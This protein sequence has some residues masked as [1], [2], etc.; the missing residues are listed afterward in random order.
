MK[1]S[2]GTFPIVSASSADGRTLVT[3]PRPESTSSDHWQALGRAVNA[4]GTLGPIHTLD[5]TP[6]G[7]TSESRLFRKFDVRQHAGRW[8]LLATRDTSYFTITPVSHDGNQ[9]A[10]PTRLNLHLELVG[11]GSETGIIRLSARGSSPDTL[12]LLD[13]SDLAIKPSFGLSSLPF[14]ESMAWSGEELLLLRRHPGSSHV[15]DFFT[16][17]PVDVALGDL[18]GQIFRDDYAARNGIG[19]KVA[20][21]DT[22]V[23]TR[24]RDMTEVRSSDTPLTYRLRVA[25]RSLSRC[26]LGRNAAFAARARRPT[27]PS[28]AGCLVCF[29]RGTSAPT[30]SFPQTWRCPAPLSAYTHPTTGDTKR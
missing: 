25:M 12:N 23:V 2:L 26:R 10:E 9:Q 18:K 5:T 30:C 20:T 22:H 19:V 1:S 15:R 29:A 27:R 17:N 14:T 21:L 16:L 13:A 8:L 28:R 3:W 7:V 6:S 4:D 24:L 11:P